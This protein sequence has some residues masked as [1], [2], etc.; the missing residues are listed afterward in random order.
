[1][2]FNRTIV[3]RIFEYFSSFLVYANISWG[4]ENSRNQLIEVYLIENFF[5]LKFHNTCF[6]NFADNGHSF[7][8]VLFYGNE[9][10]LFSFD[11]MMFLCIDVFCH[12]ILYAAIL[13]LIISQVRIA[14]LH[15]SSKN[16]YFLQV[17]VKRIQFF[18]LLP[19]WE[20]GE[21]D[22]IWPKKPLSTT[23]F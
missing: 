8:G 22:V 17:F 13:T 19:G 23:D 11:L 6:I 4:F 2:F 5:L 3:S 9:G 15:W 7:D 18:R 1:M 12:D 16:G 21:V 20:T 10:T 14:F